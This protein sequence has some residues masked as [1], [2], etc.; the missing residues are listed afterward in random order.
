MKTSKLKTN[1]SMVYSG[2]VTVKLLKGRKPYKTI[3]IHNEGSAEFFR[4]LCNAVAGNSVNDLMPKCVALF[5]ESDT[6]LTSVK[7][8]YNTISVTEN[9]GAYAT[10]LVF[11]IPGSML[12]SGEVHEI[13]LYNSASDSAQWLAK[14]EL[15]SA[16]YF[17]TDPTSNLMVVWG[18]SFQNSGTE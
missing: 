6:S 7:V 5:G 10:E 8:H 11:V 4:I 16:E 17:N 15:S 3:N 14:V 1:E 13:R 12:I 9:A 2:T 18:L